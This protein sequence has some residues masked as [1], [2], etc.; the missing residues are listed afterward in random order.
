MKTNNIKER[1]KGVITVGATCYAMDK[2]GKYIV[3]NP[4]IPLIPR[5]GIGVIATGCAS[6]GM[7]HGVG[8]IIDPELYA[9]ITNER[10]KKNQ[11]TLTVVNGANDEEED[12]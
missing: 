5:I 3:C 7:I 6:I 11:V 8:R 2:C 12:A 1:V 4:A 10:M 9:T